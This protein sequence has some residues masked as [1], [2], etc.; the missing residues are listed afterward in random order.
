MRAFEWSE[1]CS[2][3]IP[4]VDAEHRQIIELLGELRTCAFADE[5]TEKVVADAVEQLTRYADRH[6][7]R[8]ELLLRMRRYPRYEEHKAEH[9]DY[10]AKVARL[11]EQLARRDAG[12]RVSNFVNAWWRH[13]ILTSD[14][15]YARYFL[16]LLK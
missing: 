13:H 8:E 9:D 15:D 16:R 6:L 2:V 12:V 5:A 14:L 4:L 1:D 10:R 11:R 3:H 7:R